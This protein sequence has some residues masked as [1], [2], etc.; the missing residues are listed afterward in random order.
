MSGLLTA[1]ALL[2]AVTV[3]TT[4]RLA[5]LLVATARWVLPDYDVRVGSA[6]LDGLGRLA[7]RHLVV[8]SRTT[9]EIL[10]AA[11]RLQ[12]DLS[13]RAVWRG[14][15]DEVRV[16]GPLLLIPEAMSPGVSAPPES[17]SSPNWTIGRLVVQQGRVRAR[18]LADRPGVAFRFAT[19]LRDVG[20]RGQPGERS[21]RLRVRDV[22][23]SFADA[24]PNLVIDDALV[25][26]RPAALVER[27][28]VD[29]IRL[30]GLAL[31]LP[32]MTATATPADG[33]QAAAADWRI[34]RL[35]A[36]GARV[37]MAP[38]GDQ[39]GLSAVLAFDLRDL[40]FGAPLSDRRH[41]V[42]LRDLRVAPADRPPWLVV[43][44]AQA[45]FTLAE[46]LGR[47]RLARFTI[48]GGTLV[49][50]AAL[51][52]RLAAESPAAEPAAPSQASIGVLDIRR[53]RLRVTELVRGAP[54]LTL[55]F[56]TTLREV[57]LSPT[58]LTLA[59]DPQRIE[60]ADLRLYSPFDPFRQV[61]RVGSIFVDFTIADVLRQR[62]EALTIVS[63]TIFLGEDLIWYMNMARPQNTAALAPVPPWI[64]GRVRADLGRVVV[65]F[66][67]IDRLSLPVTFESRA[68]NVALDRL[69]SLHLSASLGVPRQSYTF[70]GFDLQLVDME[71]LLH[72]DYPRNVARDNVVNV[73]KVAEMRWRDYRLSDGWLSVTF[74][75]G[76]V[77]GTFGGQA[78]A[79]Y[80]DGGL[81]VPFGAG[82]TWSGW[83]AGTKLDLAPIAEL[84]AGA[85][86]ELTGVADVR[87]VIALAQG[88]RL[89]R[90]E[91]ELMLRG[92]GAVRFPALDTMLERLPADASP[93]DRDVV[94]IVTDAL[95]DFSYTTGSGRLQYA[96]AHGRA[97]LALD[98]AR[99]GRRFAL[100]YYGDAPLAAG[101][102]P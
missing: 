43:D 98:G 8:Y 42:R 93:L 49:A 50:D 40:G 86:V 19:D 76:G 6:R 82:L 14:H 55:R 60:L 68:E 80:V 35:V 87:G 84:V 53:L 67:G 78:Y 22:R 66:N 102:H 21:H 20:L 31:R 11:K 26:V 77:N 4:D 36:R 51:R 30:F 39:P 69:A 13:P 81:S 54:D 92:P 99:G 32:G 65:T 29:E 5:T 34:D 95:R 94:K 27:H 62:I 12:V 70:P 44:S 88:E 1:A 63:P 9:E 74:D 41:R 75:Q 37:E 7:V 2:S 71:G 16:V 59:H 3:L 61:V 52:E 48:D 10:F 72:F 101:V 91:A 56:E 47:E 57:P 17:G 97:E 90:A 45:E 64:V 83:I 18:R 15:L 24:P 96:D 38:A 46:L 25:T 23:V 73:L 100:H 28:T 85:G 58:A 89:E 33:E 79:G